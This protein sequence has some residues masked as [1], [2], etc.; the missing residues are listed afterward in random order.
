[1][2][3]IGRREWLGTGVITVLVVGVSGCTKMI[4]P[5]QL[6]ELKQLRA[7]EVQLAQAIR[8]AESRK[9]RIEREVASRQDELRRCKDLQ[10][11][12]Q[13]RLNS[14]PGN[15]GDPLPEAPPA[16]PVE[17]KKGRK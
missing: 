11:T 2:I 17:K 1:M 7:R 12:L 3:R 16:P 14:F 9:Q 15:L 6:S 4:Q 5:D 10:S 8:D 13:S